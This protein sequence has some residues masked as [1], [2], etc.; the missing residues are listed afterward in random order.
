[1]L[2]IIRG[3]SGS[4]KTT[5]ANELLNRFGE[6]VLLISQDAVR[7]KLRS[8]NITNSA[9]VLNYLKWLLRYGK[10][11]YKIIILEGIFSVEK[12]RLLF[13]YA[14]LLYV[15]NIFAYYYDLPFSETVLRHM[16]RKQCSEFGESE[17]RRWWHEKDFIKLFPETIIT[18]VVSLQE[19]ADMV[20]RDISK[21]S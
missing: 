7:S 16:T 17:M 12:Y 10:E 21:N 15:K 8:K 11:H 4:G 18:K 20:L 2:I 1:M 9:I 6:S 14:K 5:L 3:N 13:E 19:A